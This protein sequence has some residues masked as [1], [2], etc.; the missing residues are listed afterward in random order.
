MQ[1]CQEATS[2]LE[3]EKLEP[4]GICR[5]TTI[6]HLLEEKQAILKAEIINTCPLKEVEQER[7]ELEEIS[8]L[9]VESIEQIKSMVEAEVR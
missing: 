4:S 9:I 5:L 3:T 6:Q 2:L 7:I 1:N 8:E